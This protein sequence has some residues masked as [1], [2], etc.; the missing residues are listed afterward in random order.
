MYYCQWDTPLA[1]GNINIKSFH[2]SDLPLTMRLVL[3]P[4]AEHLSRQLSGAWAAFARTGKPSQKG[5]AWPAYTLAE[6]T[7]TVFDAPK[8]EAVSDPDRDER[9]ALRNYP[10]GNLL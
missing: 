4:E 5:Q 10:S 9:L 3:F 1:E 6:R 2:T 7:T 8:S